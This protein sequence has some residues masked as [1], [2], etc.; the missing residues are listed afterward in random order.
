MATSPPVFFSGCFDFHH[1]F[2]FKGTSERTQLMVHVHVPSLVKSLAL[3]LT[4][5]FHFYLPKLKGMHAHTLTYFPSSVP[6]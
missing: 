3:A 1:D 4:H 2:T 5:I 6:A